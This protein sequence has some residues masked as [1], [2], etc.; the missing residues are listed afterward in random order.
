MGKESAA[1]A[2]EAA[3]GDEEMEGWEERAGEETF[4]ERLV[5]RKT[6]RM[7]KTP[8]TLGTESN[9]RM[10]QEENSQIHS[11]QTG[12]VAVKMRKKKDEND[13]EKREREG[14]SGDEK[15]AGKRVKTCE[16]GSGG[17]E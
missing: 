3:R 12:M 1:R 6:I 13:K 7:E 5:G 9:R 4:C 16:H 10:R 8:W 17:A 11:K 2:G 15:K 14:G